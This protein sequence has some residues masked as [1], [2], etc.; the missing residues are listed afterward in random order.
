MKHL[1]GL[2][3]ASV[4]IF[5]GFA[6]ADPITVRSGEHANFT[7]L[8]MELPEN[9]EW[10]LVNELGRSIVIMKNFKDGFDVSDTFDIIPKTRLQALLTKPS[11]LELQL[12]CDCDVDAYIEQENF[13]VLDIQDGSTIRTN[14]QRPAFRQALPSSSFA[15]GDLLWTPNE[16]DIPDNS[17]QIGTDTELSDRSIS[18]DT[19]TDARTSDLVEETQDR[20]LRA[21]SDAAS[22]GIIEANGEVITSGKDEADVQD[23]PEVFD[24]SDILPVEPVV[25]MTNLRISNS[26]DV[27]DEAA[28]TNVSL[29]GAA[30]PNPNLIDIASW[31][32]D[33]DFSQKLAKSNAALFNDIGRVNQ[34]EALKRAKMYLYFGFGAEAKQALELV[35]GLPEAHPELLD[36]ASILEHGFARNPRSLHRFADCDSDFAL[37]GILAGT[38]I[39]PENAFNAEAAL[40]ALDKLPSPLKYVLGPELSKRF[41]DYGDV[42]NAN[43]AIRMFERVEEHDPDEP[44]I[45]DAQVSLLEG[46]VENANRI[47]E[48]IISDD[49]AEAPVAII[50]LVDSHVANN[51]RVPADIA[52]LAE[53]YAFEMRNSDLADPTF[54]AS[55]L[56]SIQ[57]DQFT[58]AFEALVLDKETRKASLK[59]ELSSFLFDS[60][61]DN[62]DGA[63]FLEG[64]FL[65]YPLLRDAIEP[66]AKLAVAK[67]LVSLGFEN[68]A[69]QVVEDLPPNSVEQEQRIIAAEILLKNGSYE[70][71]L[72]QVEGLDGNEVAM[73][74]GRALEGLGESSAAAAEFEIAQ[75]E[76]RATE[77]LWLSEDWSELVDPATPVFGS[78]GQMANEEPIDVTINENILPESQNAISASI[79]SRNTLETL[80]TDLDIAE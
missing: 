26:N 78:V 39:P 54:R 56:A 66:S 71:S 62:S 40:R 36:I 80:L 44:R 46:Q 57:S 25:P 48:E 8:V 21:F 69:Q 33:A 38:S 9:A 19:E 3:F 59:N 20:L 14:E 77:A 28:E 68:E 6:E 32:S 65:H 7:R 15:Y 60:L 12:T 31:G 73:I 13:L 52:L 24:S 63:E 11:E 30:C 41:L 53:A 47:L 43:I 61:V 64:F 58:K 42:E 16:E 55:V 51:T 79:T 4:L 34:A 35:S 2:S 23:Q 5:A 50:D 10:E 49:T 45:V 18:L 1:S 22:R 17:P 37:W 70:Q 27:P 75:A 76:D 67:R 29:A 74:R 72:E